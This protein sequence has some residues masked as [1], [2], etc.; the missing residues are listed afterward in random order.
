MRQYLRTERIALVSQDVMD[1]HPRKVCY[2]PTTG[3]AMVK[4]LAHAHPQALEVQ[5]KRGN[6]AQV[7]QATRGG[8]VDLF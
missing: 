1:I 6:A 7:A 5:E 4:R 3:K 2:F 8:S